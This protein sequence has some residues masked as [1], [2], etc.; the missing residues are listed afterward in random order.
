MFLGLAP[1]GLSAIHR[2]SSRNSSRGQNP[3]LAGAISLR[4]NSQ[5]GGLGSLGTEEVEISLAKPAPS[6]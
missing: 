3:A 1:T 2:P 6:S 5:K 4:G